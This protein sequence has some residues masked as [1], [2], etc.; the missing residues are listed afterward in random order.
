MTTRA[1]L[2]LSALLT[3]TAASAAA[4]LPPIE[5]ERGGHYFVAGGRPFFWLGDTAWE[6]IHSTTTDE[7]SYYLATRARQGFTIVQTVVLA[8]NDGLHRPTPQGTKPFRDDDPS[9][10]DDAYFDRVVAIVDEAATRGLYVGLLPAWGDKVTAPWGTGPRIFTLQNLPAARA[11]GAYLAGKLRGRTNVVWILGGDRPAVIDAQSPEWMRKYAR[12]AGVE[13]IDWR[14]IWREMAAGIVAGSA[15]APFF[16]YHPPGG[17]EGTSARLHGEPWLGMNAVQ[18]GHGGGHDV[19]VWEIIERD[20]ALAPAKPVLDMEPNYEDHPVN[21]WPVWNP[22]NGYFRDHD[23]RKQVYRSVFAGGAGVTYGHHAVWPFVGD[24]NPPINHTDRDWRDALTRPAASQMQYLRFLLE[25]RPQSG[26]IPDQKLIHVNADSRACHARA[27]RGD[28]YAF[29][30][31]PCAGQTLQIDGSALAA[32]RLRAW[33]Y[34]PRNGVAQRGEEIPARDATKFISP[35]Q[36]P[37]WVLVLD[38]ASRP[39]AP[40]GLAK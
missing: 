4:A 21:P 11:Y 25:S 37:D 13:S 7:A 19:P 6:L 10:P 23:V 22:A 35:G 18:S 12:D 15:R 30:Y 20:F 31:F 16:A 8:E 36:G 17:S 27:T 1:G 38:D 40:P 32:G 33:W 2:L 29:V 28:G 9:K 3:A 26:R 34:D 24:R 39:F 5:V 14:P